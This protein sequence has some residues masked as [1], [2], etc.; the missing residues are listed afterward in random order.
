M[1]GVCRIFILTITCRLRN[2]YVGAM[3][4]YLRIPSV[5]GYSCFFSGFR[6]LN[7]FFIKNPFLPFT[8]RFL[9]PETE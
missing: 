4:K 2:Q 1:K 3:E 6:S 5:Q 7:D 8:N 9:F